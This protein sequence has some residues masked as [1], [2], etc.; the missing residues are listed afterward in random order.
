ML[1]LVT[2]KSK[3]TSLIHGLILLCLFP[4]QDYSTAD[5]MPADGG[6]ASRRADIMERASV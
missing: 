3:N 6:W 1:H 5:G 2:F 4:G